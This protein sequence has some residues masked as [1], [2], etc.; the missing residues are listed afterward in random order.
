MN[1]HFFSAV[2]AC[3]GVSV[4]V[5]RTQLTVSVFPQTIIPRALLYTTALV[6][7]KVTAQCWGKC[8][9]MYRRLDSNNNVPI[10]CGIVGGYYFG[11]VI[12]AV[13]CLRHLRRKLVYMCLVKSYQ[14]GY[15]APGRYCG[16]ERTSP[17]YHICPINTC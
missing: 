4:V 13:S 7:P 3:I 9:P 12:I 15:H 1:V 11:G 17:Y 5:S 14:N 16:L 6:K 8:R 10:S 2:I